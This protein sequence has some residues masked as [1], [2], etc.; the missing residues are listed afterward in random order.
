MRF[1]EFVA[2]VA[3]PFLL[4]AVRLHLLREQ[5]PVPEDFRIWEGIYGRFDETPRAGSG[6]SGERVVRAAETETRREIQ[7]AREG[8]VVPWQSAGALLSLLGAVVCA[9]NGGRVRIVDFGGGTGVDFVH[10]INVLPPGA[11]VQYHIVELAAECAAGRRLFPDDRRLCFHEDIPRDL[12]A[13]DIVCS[14]SALQYVDDYVGTL[15]K[16]CALRARYLVLLRLSAGNIP[17]FVSAQ[18][19]LPGVVVPHWFFNLDEI[20]ALAS[21]QKYRVVFDG[22]NDRCFNQQH[23]PERYRLNRFRNVVFA[24]SDDA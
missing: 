2:R 18:R 11:E 4:D 14:N 3:P 13:V 10:L 16:L 20:V 17:T 12:P 1:R 22:A 23:F 9:W 15:H 19:N 21:A 7:R 24:R 8:G 6:Y 5:P